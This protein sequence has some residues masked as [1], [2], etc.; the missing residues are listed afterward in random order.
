MNITITKDDIANVEKRLLKAQVECDLIELDELLHDDLLFNVPGGITITKE[1]DLAAYRSANM[2]VESI[3]PGEYQIS[4]FDDAA[5]AVVT[6]RLKG[7]FMKEPIDNETRFIR[8]WKNCN[9]KLKVI[10]GASAII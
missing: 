4:L 3:I 7:E 9:G 1:M 2:I 6:V 5:V 8:V 10:G